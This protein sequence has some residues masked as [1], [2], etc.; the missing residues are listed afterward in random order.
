MSKLIQLLTVV[1]FFLYATSGNSQ[2]TSTPVFPVDAW[3]VYSWT[4]LKGLNKNNA[5]HIKG[6]PMIISWSSLEPQNGKFEFEKEIGDKLKMIEGNNFY[7]FLKIWVAPATTNVTATDT[8]WNLT[9][10]WLF[11]NG[12]PLVEFPK[13]INP[14]GTTTIRY[15]PYYLDEK[16]KF[17]FHRMIDAVGKYVLSLP[18]HLRKRILYI[19]SAEGS[20]GDGGPY[21]GEPVNSAYAI[22]KQQWTDFRL[23]TWVKY[24]SAFS[25]DGVLQFPL[26]TNYDANDEKLYDWMLNE[27]PNAAGLKNGMFS[28]GYQISDAQQRLANFIDFRNKVEARGKVFFAR[29]EMDGEYGKYGW[30]TKNLKQA[31]YWSAIYATN[32][33]LTMWNL[34]TE[35]CL[36]EIYVDAIQFFNKY[37]AE[38]N[39]EKAKG[40]FCAFYRGLD[41]SDTTSFPESIYGKATKKNSERYINITKA[42]S[43]Y[44]ANQADAEKA[45]GGGMDNR[46]AKGYNDAGWQILKENFQRH[47]TQIE[48]ET[49]SAAWWQIDTSIYGRYARGFEPATGKNS[50]YFNLDDK[51]FG[52]SPLNGLQAIEVSITYR[53]SDAGSWELKYDATN[54][55]M[56]T[57]M[58]VI[59]S[60]KGMG[61]WK[62]AKVT[63]SDAYL[64]NRG[65]KGADFMLVNTG[66]T[67]CRFHLIAVDKIIK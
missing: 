3:G 18:P 66:G 23:E 52:T 48:P 45:T 36:G 65:A 62:T 35:A 22:S 58:T 24:K 5:P 55:T 33:G 41:A 1:F 34:P 37:A 30:S 21:K 16:Y 4:G 20:T 40:A 47:I 67:N 14:M 11:K 29:G 51:F 8:S 28:H 50:L 9:P 15:F 26:L 25:K 54:G 57:A 42:F 19:Q 64:G 49:T 32:G 7:T 61:V 13:T 38:T 27:L 6:G 59:N 53:D 2:A 43:K 12:V 17:Y 39:P 46:K 56:K 60:G 10:K 63:L 31:M 44:G